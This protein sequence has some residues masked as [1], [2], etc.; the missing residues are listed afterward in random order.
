MIQLILH[1]I[2]DFITQT[3]WMAS[4]KAKMTKTGY[5][6]CFIHATIYSLPFLFIGSLNAFLVIWYTHFIIDK[7][8]LAIPLTKLKNWNWK[9]EN[10]GFNDATPVW[11][12]TWLFIIIDNIMHIIC[13][14][15]S[16][17]YL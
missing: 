9:S 4:N 17:K 6:S 10:Y 8:R 15:L 1:A 14:Y 13:N 11:L 16:L 2:G 5:L 3:E 7:Y 12:S